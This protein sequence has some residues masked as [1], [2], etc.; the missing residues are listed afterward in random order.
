MDLYLS[1]QVDHFMKCMRTFSS[2]FRASVSRVARFA[3]EPL[4]FHLES[5]GQRIFRPPA[6]KVG[7]HGPPGP[8]NAAALGDGWRAVG[9]E[10]AEN[11]LTRRFGL[12]NL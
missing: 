5:G 8:P 3:R 11:K 7:G 6:I 2:F 9:G 12:Y 1:A 4:F 10:R